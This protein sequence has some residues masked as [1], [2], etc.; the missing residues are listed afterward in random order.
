MSWSPDHEACIDCGSA[1]RKHAGHGLCTRCYSRRRR[2]GTRPSHGAA[3]AR[4]HACCVSCG[5]TQREHHAEG[6]CTAC[7]AAQRRETE[8]GRAAALAAQR[9]YAASLHGRL[10]RGSWYRRWL[11]KPGSGEKSRRWTRLVRD[12]AHGAEIDI[13][14]GYETL[15]FEVFGRRCAACGAEREG[16][17]LDHH[18]PLERGHVLLHNAVPLCTSC[19]VRKGSRVPENFYDAWKYTEI[20]VLLWETWGKFERRFGGEAAA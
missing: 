16:L 10:V 7:Y 8:S 14:L 3:W 4:C 1:E 17:V 5:D 15:V 11:S 12:R 6:Q 20:E 13:P 18:R 2:A 19:N 9:R